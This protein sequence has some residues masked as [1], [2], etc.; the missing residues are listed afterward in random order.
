MP[1]KNESKLAC[2]LVLVLKIKALNFSPKV[3]INGLCELGHIMSL[4]WVYVKLS[5]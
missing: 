5:Q 2:A 4:P 3:T 1:G